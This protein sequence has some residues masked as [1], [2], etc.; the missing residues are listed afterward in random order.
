METGANVGSIDQL[1]AAKRAVG[2]R[3]PNA[4]RDEDVDLL[5]YLNLK[6]AAQGVPI[7]GRAE[8][9]PILKLSH[10][11]LDHV[12][13]QN[14]YL[15][16]RLC[17]AD[18]TIQQFLASYLREFAPSTDTTWL[19]TNTLVLERHGLARMLSLP[20]DQDKHESPILSSY[21]TFQGICHNPVKDRRTTEGVFHIV[22]GGFTV[23]ADKKETPRRTFA[24]LLQAAKSPPS[25]LAKLPFTATQ[26]QQAETFVSLLLRPK[27]CPEV[28]GFT[29]EKSIEVRF[30]APGSLVANLD[31]V[32]SIFGNAE[33]GRAHV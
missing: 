33:I 20:P 31:F 28:A 11:L 18:A 22:E 8:D 27:V 14:R 1:D 19:P 32:E 26:K 13:V 6:L 24:A 5:Q 23:P 16:N 2:Y 17:P 4:T 29:P 7:Y 25:D 30:F 10:S 3:S 15:A 9:Y 12:R 21:R